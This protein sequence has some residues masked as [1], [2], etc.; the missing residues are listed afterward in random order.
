VTW[1]YFSKNCGNH[2]FSEEKKRVS[3]PSKEKSYQKASSFGL[4]G[5]MKMPFELK[6]VNG[7]RPWKSPFAFK[8]ALLIKMALSASISR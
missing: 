6:V 3:A 5:Q 7:E 4:T 2:F 8:P 1:S